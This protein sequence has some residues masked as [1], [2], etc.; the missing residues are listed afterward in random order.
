[1]NSK[2]VQVVLDTELIAEAKIFGFKNNKNLKD[3]I[4]EGLKWYLDTHDTTGVKHSQPTTTPNTTITKAVPTQQEY[5]PFTTPTTPNT[6]K[7]QQKS[8]ILPG[9]GYLL[10]KTAKIDSPVEDEDGSGYDKEFELDGFMW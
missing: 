9:G 4:A 1:M 10:R 6:P 8:N 2:R 3:M 7:P 5:K